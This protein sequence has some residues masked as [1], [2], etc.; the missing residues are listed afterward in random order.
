MASSESPA[1]SVALDIAPRISTTS[2]TFSLPSSASS[3]A[4]PPSFALHVTRLEDSLMLWL[5]LTDPMSGR[6]V[7]QK[8][9]YDW[10]CAVPPPPNRTS[11]VGGNCPRYA[12]FQR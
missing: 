9:A 2:R 8:L 11:S 3:F 7:S 12:M 6:V 5:G 1:P 4:S 10:A